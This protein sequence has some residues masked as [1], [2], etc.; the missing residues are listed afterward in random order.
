MYIM[1]KKSIIFVVLISLFSISFSIYQY[2]REFKT[3]LVGAAYSSTKPANGHTWSEMECSSTL[4]LTGG[5]T[6]LGTSTPGYKLDVQGGQINA[7]DGLCIA[8]DC[9]T[10]WSAISGTSTGTR[11][12]AG[13]QGNAGA[14]SG[15]FQ[16]DGSTVTNY[17][18]G[19]SN[20]WHLLDI[21]H[22]NPNNNYALQIAGSFFDQ[23]L[24][25]RKTNNNP[26]ASW[27]KIVYS[28]I[29]SNVGIGT[30]SPSQKLEV[31]GNILASGDICNGSGACLSQLN[32]FI[33]SQPI[34]GGTDHNRTNCTA[35][36][37]VGGSTKGVLVYQDGLANPICRFAGSSC[38]SSWHQYLSWC[39]YPVKTCYGVGR[40]G[41]WYAGNCSTLEKPWAN[42]TTAP[43]SCAYYDEDVGGG[44]ECFYINLTCTPDIGQ[45]GCY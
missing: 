33:G 35:T 18:A 27:N 2:V 30:A 42:N 43:S 32:S 21:R 45:I 17:P 16:N 8:G 38:P 11:T 25:F 26:S 37:S 36:N 39:T 31:N 12:D 15:F 29:N 6:G 14:T 23:D 5:N 28:G 7:S 3:D 1:N 24:Y 13:L 4:C 20:W 10:N 19:A 22:S 41:C 40:G 34:A 44:S 9:K